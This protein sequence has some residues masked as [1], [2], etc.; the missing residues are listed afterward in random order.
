MSSALT[1]ASHGSPTITGRLHLCFPTQVYYLR[2]KRHR[3]IKSSRQSRIENASAGAM[4]PITEWH[5]CYPSALPVCVS[6]VP[7]MFLPVAQP[8]RTASSPAVLFQRVQ[9][10]SSSNQQEQ[11]DSCW[12]VL[13]CQ[14]K[15]TSLF[16]R[17][18]GYYDCRSET[19]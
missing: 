1:H 13:F 3:A 12:L 19:L 4:P 10:P 8:R 7:S 9:S 17:V 6:P 15:R 11:N 2:I 18:C 14:V 16:V 5:V